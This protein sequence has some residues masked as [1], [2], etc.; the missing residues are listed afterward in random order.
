MHMARIEHDVMLRRNSPGANTSWTSDKYNA[1]STASE[2]STEGEV[3]YLRVTCAISGTQ[4][5]EEVTQQRHL[6]FIDDKARGGFWLSPLQQR[7]HFAV[8]L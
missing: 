3:R 5:V 8:R 7:R 6:V 1:W 4:S 2:C